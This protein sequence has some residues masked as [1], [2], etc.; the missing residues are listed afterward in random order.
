MDPQQLFTLI[1]L[2]YE[3]AFV[4][5]LWPP[6]LGRISR[7]SEGA[8][9]IL[10][11]TNVNGVRWTASPDIHPLFEEFLRDGWHAINQRPARLGAA[12]V[13]GFVRDNEVFSPEEMDN[14][15]VYTGFY[16][17]RGLGWAAGTM[18]DVPS[19]DAIIFSF[20]RAWEKGPVPE[21]TI[22]HLNLLRPHLARAALVSSRF[23][24]EKAKAMTL[25]L[26]QSGFAAAVLRKDGELYATNEKFDKL[27]HSVFLD[28]P[29]RL[30]L[31]DHAA[32]GLLQRG[33]RSISNETL[34]EARTIP[35][36]AHEDRPP[37]ILHLLPIKRAATDI[38]VQ[39]NV[40]L[41]VAPVDRRAV[42]AAQVVAG[43][44][45]LTAGEA[46][47]AREIA[48]GL[49]VEETAEICGI[50]RETVRTH[51]KRTFAKTGTSRQAEL[52]AL[53]TGAVFPGHAKD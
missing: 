21:Q 40:L 11:T 37:L 39:G 46:R 29:S 47:V 49:S 22:Q 34:D 9:G 50:S 6:L 20:E 48:K 25:A 3:A 26:A 1:D 33:L 8:G 23:G 2:I 12:N 51:L 17:K 45:D 42:P 4:P 35:L 24:L 18:L 43:L 53:L 41:I 36:A 44:F 15:P 38:F 31:V 16:R 5:E 52:V 30:V 19:G 32:D 27:L 10:F 14:D 7:M 28:T 13:A